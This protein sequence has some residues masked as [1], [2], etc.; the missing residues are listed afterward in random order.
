M[1]LNQTSWT[2]SIM[3]LEVLVFRV[4]GLFPVFCDFLR[5]HT[6]YVYS[7]IEARSCNRFCSV[8]I[9]NITCYA[10]VSVALGIQHTIYLP[11]IVVC[12][13]SGSVIVFLSLA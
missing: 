10:C 1:L 11:H 3:K 13:Y 5:R 2:N 8:N 6:M 4:T 9:I 12:G 7:N